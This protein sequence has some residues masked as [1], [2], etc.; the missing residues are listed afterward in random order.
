M[1]LRHEQVATVEAVLGADVAAEQRLIARVRV[2]LPGPV[3]ANELRPRLTI[4]RRKR[5]AQIDGP[6]L[7]DHV[8]LVCHGDDRLLPP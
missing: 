5:D 7:L 3:P 6:E 2:A 8:E 1:L 4:G